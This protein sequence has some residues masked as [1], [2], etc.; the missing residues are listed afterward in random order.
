MAILAS[1]QHQPRVN[2]VNPLPNLDEILENITKLQHPIA[3]PPPLSSTQKSS[4][5]LYLTVGIIAGILLI[6][7]IILIAMCLLRLLQR[8]RFL[9]H[10]K[11]VNGSGEYY[12]EALHKNVNPDYATSPCLQ[13][14]VVSVDG[15]LI[16]FAYPTKTKSPK[17]YCHG[18]AHNPTM[19][20]NN[21]IRL[22]TNPITHLENDTN[23][24]NF[25]HTLTP[26]SL[27]SQYEE[28]PLHHRLL[29]YPSDT[30]PFLNPS[31]AFPCGHHHSCQRTYMA[32][33]ISMSSGN[34][35]LSFLFHKE[36][37][38]RSFLLLCR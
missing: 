28:C 13:H 11:S 37:N 26:F 5:I 7:M 6:L 20:E 36:G 35:G 9:S 23:Q 14:G 31:Q 21:G 10:M 33:G 4:D 8:K 1:T 19:H 17:I 34:K 29:N 32:K 30:L 18:L 3:S 2:P 24:E 38:M 27:H 12:C 15:K 25:Y 22:S 16:P